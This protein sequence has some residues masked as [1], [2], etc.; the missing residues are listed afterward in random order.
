MP[1]RIINT[2]GFAIVAC[3]MVGDALAQS[4]PNE[5]RLTLEE[6]REV[7]ALEIS[8]SLGTSAELAKS[9]L[10]VQEQSRALIGTIRDKYADRLA[11]MYIE[12]VP[13]HRLV[14]RLVGA[15]PEDTVVAEYGPD[16]LEVVFETGALHTLA[17]LMKQFETA[18]PKLRETIP[19]LQG[20]FVDERTGEIVIEISE[21][22][23]QMVADSRTFE[24]LT[25]PVRVKW[26]T[27]P[28][29]L[30]AVFGSGRIVYPKGGVSYQCTTGFVVKQTASGAFGIASAGHC[31]SD[32]G[33]YNYTGADSA[34][35]VLSLAGSSRTSTSD[36]NWMNASGVGFGPWFYSSTGW[37]Q[38]TAVLQQTQTLVG[39]VVCRYKA[40][41]GGG[42]GCGTV[43][44]VAYYPGSICGPSEVGICL[45]T[46]VGVAGT[47]CSAGGGSGG[48]WYFNATWAAGIHMGSRP[49]AGECFYTSV[50]RLSMMGVQV[51]L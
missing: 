20:G 41:T 35:H 46:F 12:H 42:E 14:V 36:L 48:P 22:D 44:S 43:T 38:V 4:E 23:R 1:K 25:V 7:T 15:E 24:S 13:T 9:I 3:L 49:S 51:L 33:L 34:T 26:T 10:N 17:E 5:S 11:G 30:D 21:A 18:L 37:R 50:T 16:K 31:A 39:D 40:G 45:S 32:T 6:A 27:E 8:E 28:N 19:G 2:L 29:Q 47:T